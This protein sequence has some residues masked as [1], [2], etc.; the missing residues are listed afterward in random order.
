MG[1]QF[2]ALVNGKDNHEIFYPH[3]VKKSNFP[4]LTAN[5]KP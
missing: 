2:L 1:T 4:G 5:P 3:F